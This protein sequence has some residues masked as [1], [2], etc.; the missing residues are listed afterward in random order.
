MS[1]GLLDN[2]TILIPAHNR[3]ERL[4]RLIGYYR[5]TGAK[6]LIPDSSDIK[7]TGDID[8]DN[9][10]Y[11]HYPRTHMLVKV[12]DVLDL[13]ATP[14]V[15]YCAD[16]DFAV[17][18]GL[19]AAARFL[20]A[21]PDFCI[22]QGHYLTFTP[23][24]DGSV[25]FTPRYIRNFDCRID[26]GYPLDRL[27]AEKGMYA[28]LLYALTRT[29]T[30][31]NIYS[32]CFDE[33]GTLLFRNLFLAEEY[34]NHAALLAGKYATLPVFFSARERIKGSATDTTVPSSV[35]KNAP[36]YAD[37]YKGFLTA[38]A[39]S[40]VSAT[41]LSFEEAFQKAGIVSHAPVDSKSVL[42]K[43]RVNSILAKSRWLRWASNLSEWRYHQKGLKAVRGMESY[44]CR[45]ITPQIE[46][47]I[48][49]VNST[50]MA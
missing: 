33:N 30:F 25:E 2:V 43:R 17:P 32:H 19:A 20:D 50:E 37:D 40:M 14:Y 36:E 23:N 24:R 15:V 6:L 5:G 47:I 10:I 46:R 3:P 28:S 48:S 8:D 26:S 44:P 21:N 11:R 1:R 42:F 29:S 13:I 16:D 31:R 45:I 34:F 12:R 27:S 22:A 35:I 9:I 7:F 4:S 41:G 38:V 39:N 18:E 49:C